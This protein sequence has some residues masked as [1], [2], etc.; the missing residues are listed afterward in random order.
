MD[1]NLT[2]ERT[3]ELPRK[4]RPLRL[5]VIER[6]KT[7]QEEVMDMEDIIVK[8]KLA[9]HISDEQIEALN[10]QIKELERQIVKIIE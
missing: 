8:E 2:V 9:E 5:E 10:N 6:L 3:H 4:Y 7:L 1:E